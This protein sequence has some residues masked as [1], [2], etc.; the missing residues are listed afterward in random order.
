M[1]TSSS[2]SAMICNVARRPLVSATR[3]SRYPIADSDGS[4]RVA[5]WPVS[6]KKL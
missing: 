2:R 6:T 1:G 5:I 4:I 3:T